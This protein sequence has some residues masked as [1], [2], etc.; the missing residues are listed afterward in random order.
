MK[1]FLQIGV[2]TAVMLA[3]PLSALSQDG[4]RFANVEVTATPVAGSVYVLVG[5]GGNVGVSAGEDGVLMIDDQFAGLAEK[6]ATTVAGLSDSAPRYVINTH[7][8]GD[9]TGSNAFF[10][11]NKGSTIFAHENVRIRLA[12][13]DKISKSA[14]PVVTYQNGIK[15]HLNDETIHVIHLADA[16]TDGD[17]VVWFEQP[18]VL[19]MG[20]LFFKDMFPYIDL[21]AGGTVKGY[22]TAVETLIAKIDDDTHVIPGHG[23]PIANRAD[24]QRFV[25][26]IK[27]TYAFVQAKKAAGMS[28]DDVLTAGLDAKWDSWSW[29][30]INEERWIK[31]LYQ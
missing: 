6:I 16:H 11:E 5:A 3:M 7:Y 20:D 4:D 12:S 9:H 21:G 30:F 29:A 28:E 22:I 27:A 10:K 31:T 25:D 14:L 1:N 13:D 8:H 2:L 24:L 19:H 23:G 18:D 17:S 26:M 15:F